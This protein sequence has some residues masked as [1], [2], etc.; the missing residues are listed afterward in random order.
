MSFVEKLVHL[1]N[2]EE[3]LVKKLAR[4]R[5]DKEK[6]KELKKLSIQSTVKK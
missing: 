2:L 5:A 4:I 1:Y 6:E 3:V